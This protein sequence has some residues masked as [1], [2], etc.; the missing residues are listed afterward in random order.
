MKVTYKQCLSTPG[1]KPSN[2]KDEENDDELLGREEATMYRALVARG[3][4]LSQDRSDILFAVEELSRK[5]A[6]PTI[7][8]YRRLKRLGRY[9]HTRPRVVTPSEYQSSPSELCAWTDSDFAGFHASRKS[10]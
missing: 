3:N 2:E 5:M 1:V 4:Y 10:T 7:G 6:E 9:L 8:C